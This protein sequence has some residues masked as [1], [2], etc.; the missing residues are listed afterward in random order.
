MR[1]VTVPTSLVSCQSRGQLLLVAAA[2]RRDLRGAVRL[3]TAD[4]LRVTL[5]DLS[6]LGRVTAL[7]A[8]HR[9]LRVVGEP[10]VAAF[11][12]LVPASMGRTGQLRRMAALASTMIRKRP[13]EVVGRVTTLAFDAGVKRRVF[14]CGLMARAAV[15]GARLR[16]A[17]AGMWVVT[18]DARA[19]QALLRVIWLLGGVA[20][21]TSLIGA[22]AHV[23]RT[24]AA[25]ALPMCRHARLTEHL[26]V[27]VTTAAG[28]GLFL[29]KF[30]RPMTAHALHVPAFEQRRCRDDRLPFR[31]ARRAGAQGIRSRGVLFLVAS[32]A[33]LIGRLALERV[34]RSD[35]LMA[36][37]AGPRLRCRLLVWLVAAQAL[38]AGMNLHGRRVVLRPQVAVRTVPCLVSVS[39]QRGA[40]RIGL[41]RA[42]RPR[43]GE[44]MT[45]RAVAAGGGA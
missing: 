15:A 29:G 36:L 14:V 32:G 44:A 38:F 45:E 42:E 11:A 35:L 37:T 4:A 24:V 19:C 8:G 22:A 1:L 21:G 26:H 17:E 20:P 13:D 18:T 28:R 5:A 6:A 41:Q 30:V 9:Q 43:V 12:G 33:N 39:S 27:L 31:M 40:R 7:T 34:R 16:V 25:R 2:A 3:V 23:V 10:D